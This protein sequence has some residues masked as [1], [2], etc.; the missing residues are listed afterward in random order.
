MATISASG[1]TSLCPGGSVVL[2][3]SAVTDAIYNWKLNGTSLVSG[4]SNTYSANQSG[5]YTVSVTSTQGCT[6]TSSSPTFVTVNSNP[7]ISVTSSSLESSCGAAVTSTASGAATYLWSNGGT[8]ST[9]SFTGAGSYTVTGT[10]SAGCTGTAS[11]TVSNSSSTTS[12]AIAVHYYEIP[13][14]SVSGGTAVCLNETNPSVTFTATN[15][16]AA[17]YTFVYNIN[18]GS[19]LTTTTTGSNLSA[20]VS[21]PTTVAGTFVYTLVSINDAH[22]GQVLSGAST[23]VTVNALP[24]ALSVT[25]STY[26][27]YSNL[28]PNTT[29]GTVTSTSSV[30]GVDYELYDS[31]GVVPNSTKSGTGNALTWSNVTDGNYYVVA[32]NPLGACSSTSATLNVAG[33]VAIYSYYLDSDADGYGTGTALQGCAAT[34]PAGYSLNTGDCNNSNS[35]YYP[36]AVEICGNGIDENCSGPSDDAPIS[37]RSVTSGNWGD[38]S[39]WEMACYAGSAY[40]AATYA[41]VSSFTGIASIQSTH[42]VVIPNNGTIYQTGTLD[43]DAGGT[44]T[45]TGN[46]YNNDPTTANVSPV[47]KLTV[48][49]VIINDGTMNVGH[50]ASLVQTATTAGTVNSGSG[51]F[52]VQ[53][54]LTGNWSSPTGAPNGRYWYIGSPMNNTVASQ[55]FDTPSM[56][57][58]WRYNATNNSWGIVIHSQ[59]STTSSLKLVPGIG[60]LYRAGANKTITYTSTAANLNNNITTNLLAPASDAAYIPVLGYSTI[61]YKYVANPYPSHVDWTLLSRTGLNAGYWIR[62]ASNTSYDAYNATTQL[63]SSASGQTTKY[64][65][66]MQGFWVYAYTTPS[67]LKIDNTDRVH[68]TNV[69]HAPNVNQVVRLKLNNGE[70]SDYTVVYENELAAN[71]FEEADTDKMFDYDFHQLYTLEGEHE[72]VLNGLSNA[73]SKGSV[74]MGISVANNGQ[75]TIEATDLEMEED[76]ILEDRFNH[77]FQDMKVNPIYSFTTNA[78]TFN[79]RFVLHFTATE[80]VAVGETGTVADEVRVFNTSN[81]QVKVWVSNTSEYQGATVKVFDA[82]GNL[83]ERKNMTSNELLLDLD[84]A[85]GIYVVEITGKTE[86]FTKKIFIGK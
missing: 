75:Y 72:L 16:G 15:T 29:Y 61:G 78:G 73:T 4:L 34:A 47:A 23:T 28:V 85:N 25:G 40:T 42:E 10:S 52:N 76:V 9:G 14:A 64:I 36:T 37:Y 66:P 13:S 21:V 43:I 71:D 20:M 79:E 68:S 5:G 33:T 53:S 80:S 30:S 46:D 57:R 83:V 65:A 3:A 62:N 81:Q 70:S 41:P 12:N 48:T 44:L 54:K 74:D 7:T 32:T 82:I 18:G 58:L 26:C 63:G 86:V 35:A 49:L 19:N 56:V 50:Q 1:S 2:S 45:M 55:F 51:N 77:T 31:N 38:A 84:I 27:S 24:A 6:A 67:A 69:L 11:V 17:P 39:T 59:T 8:S 22:C 60:Y